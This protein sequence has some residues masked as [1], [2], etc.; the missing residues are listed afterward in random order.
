MPSMLV[1]VDS[2]LQ[3][4]NESKILLRVGV[5]DIG[6]RSSWNDLSGLDFDIGK[7]FALFHMSGTTM[8]H[9]P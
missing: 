7:T 6:R 2:S 5:S 1:I 4:T 8:A 3:P 9:R